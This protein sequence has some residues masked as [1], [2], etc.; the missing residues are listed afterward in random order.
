MSDLDAR[1]TVLY[2]IPVGTLRCV[3]GKL[4][5]AGGAFS[6]D[7]EEADNCLL[8]RRTRYIQD[9]HVSEGDILQERVVMDPASDMSLASQEGGLIEERTGSSERL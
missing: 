7:V 4:F 2:H 3:C 9:M 5:K 8:V 1:M 6:R